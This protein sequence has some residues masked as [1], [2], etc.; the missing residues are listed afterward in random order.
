MTEDLEAAY[1][2]GLFDGEGHIGITVTKNGRGEK[3]HRLQVNVTNTNITVIHWL[4]ERFGG[5]IHNPRY[6]TS[7]NWREA[8][9]WTI[10]DGKASSFLQTVLPYLIIKKSQAEL[11]I[12]FQATKTKGGFGTPKPDLAHRDGLRETISK[13]NRGVS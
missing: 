6:F 12:E 8:H 1:A 3:Y 9:R 11:A 10:A 7:E 13:L 4:F 5:C 2:A